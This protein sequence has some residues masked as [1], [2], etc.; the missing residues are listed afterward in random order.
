MFYD[1]A[2][3]DVDGDRSVHLARLTP[4]REGASPGILGRRGA[5][6]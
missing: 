1:V 5:A 6:A 2:E 4:A 3:R